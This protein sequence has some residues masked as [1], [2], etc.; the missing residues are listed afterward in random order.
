MHFDRNSKGNSKSHRKNSNSTMSNIPTNTVPLSTPIPKNNFGIPSRYDQLRLRA[1]VVHPDD[2]T[3]S[4]IPPDFRYT[5]KFPSHYPESS[6]DW[7]EPSFDLNSDSL[8]DNAPQK[9]PAEQ[10]NPQ[11]QEA[12]PANDDLFNELYLDNSILDDEKPK[13][14]QPAPP[15]WKM[16]T[17]APARTC[18]CLNNQ[19][20]YE[21]L[22]DAL[23]FWL[24]GLKLSTESRKIYKYKV[25]KL[26]RLLDDHHI[27]NLTQI[28]IQ[29][30][31]DK[32]FDPNDH[33][34]IG[35]FKSVAVKFFKWVSYHRIYNKIRPHAGAN[36]TTTAK[37]SVIDNKTQKPVINLTTQF[38][39]KTLSNSFNEWSN[40]L[41]DDIN[42]NT[43]YKT[44]ILSFIVFLIKIKTLSPTPS[45]IENYF[46]GSSEIPKPK[47][48]ESCKKAINSFLKFLEQAAI[49][50]DPE[51]YKLLESNETK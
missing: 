16:Q 12:A 27:Y 51:V 35:F 18:V 5:I 37:H 1:S 25:I 24:H 29:E 43:I 28:Q 44:Q 7:G 2:G 9:V 11:L 6:L 34:N 3:F 39:T 41:K 15:Q 38:V 13:K 49:P 48:I 4:P 20:L 45:D 31:C 42:T 21:S 23:N 40:T 46:Q 17:Y 32:T 36:E 33:Y 30:Y 8:D 14:K 47:D 26:V 10:N 19:Y 50:Q 22:E